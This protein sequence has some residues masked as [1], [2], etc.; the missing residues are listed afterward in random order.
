MGEAALIDS[1]TMCL[2]VDGCGCDIVG[3]WVWMVVSVWF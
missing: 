3:V 1:T 2:C